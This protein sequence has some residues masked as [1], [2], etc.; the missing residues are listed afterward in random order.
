M[1]IKKLTFNEENGV[2]GEVIIDGVTIDQLKKIMD[3]V[4]DFVPNNPGPAERMKE[5]FIQ[6]EVDEDDDD[7]GAE[8][9]DTE[10]EEPEENNGHVESGINQA[11]KELIEEIIQ[12]TPGITTGRMIKESRI[13]Y[14]KARKLL[15]E[16]ES[17]GRVY[18]KPF[19]GSHKLYD[20]SVDPKSI[21][22]SSEKVLKVMEEAGRQLSRKE[23][24][25]KSGLSYQIVGSVLTNLEE[26]KAIHSVKFKSNW[27]PRGKKFYALPDVDITGYR[28]T[29]KKK[30]SE[31]K[32]QK[33]LDELKDRLQDVLRE[34]EKMTFTEVAAAVLGEDVNTSGEE[35]RM[36]VKNFGFLFQ[37]GFLGRVLD[38]GKSVYFIEKEYL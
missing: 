18:I 6:A 1:K 5:P 28:E 36:F 2:L 37:Q 34:G 11:D 38:M 25:D 32:L 14:R 7:I 27:S 15:G 3:F 8:E 19:K 35:Y 26:K 10:D 23:I 4:N 17:E 24:T 12:K 21:M 29:S 20:S 30:K 13:N 31:E 22:T 16:L 9:S 33:T